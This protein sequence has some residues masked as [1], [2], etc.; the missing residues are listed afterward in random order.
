MI[1]ITEASYKTSPIL[2][3][4][5]RNFAKLIEYYNKFAENC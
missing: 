3:D 5:E 1:Y 4:V 2:K